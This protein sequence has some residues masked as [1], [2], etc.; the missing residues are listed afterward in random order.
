MPWNIPELVVV[1]LLG[2]TDFIDKSSF[3]EGF[4]ATKIFNYLLNCKPKWL[5]G[6]TREPRDLARLLRFLYG[7]KMGLLEDSSAELPKLSDFWRMQRKAKP[8]GTTYG[9][10]RMPCTMP[11]AENIRAASKMIQFN[12]KYWNV[13]W[14]NTFRKAAMPSRNE[15]EQA[16]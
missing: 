4:G 3:L 11:C 15:T 5:L 12:F 2:G 9:A 8:T 1:L 7:T 13:D 10:Q 14:I 6:A 16:S